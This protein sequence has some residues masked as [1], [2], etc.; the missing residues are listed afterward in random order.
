MG[1]PAISIILPTFNR[2]NAI[3]NAIDSILNQTFTSLEIVI[4][5]DASTDKT[6]E[7]VT[8][9]QKKDS[10]IIYVQNK[11]N[12]G[13]SKSRNIGLRYAQAD[14]IA[15]MDDDDQYADQDVLISLYSK[16]KS[17]SAE[18]V[19]ANYGLGDELRLMK[20]F[21]KDFKSN[22][23]KS[24]GPF[25]QCIL[26][27]KQ[28]IKKA[29]VAFDSQAIPSEDWDFFITISKLN[30]IVAHCKYVSF[31]WNVNHNSQ[32]LDFLK[33]ANALAY[34]YK[35]HKH[36]I[37]KNLN[38][39]IISNHYRRVARVYEKANATSQVHTFYK[40]AFT[41]YPLSIKNIFYWMMIK[42]GYQNTKTLIGWIRKLRGI[43][44]A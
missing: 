27:K 8:T 14:T 9:Y 35:K 40:K 6:Y 31:I 20:R 42:I 30:P 21:E 5:D 1:K 22:I 43:P 19:I 3:N 24:P 17:E 38:S 44:N 7:L 23:I 28:L 15:F 26:I 25:L 39:K 36:Y 16:M 32:S 34:I 12:V 4:V 41:E 33:E 18:L 29:G 11:E 37:A 10:R 2:A 13:C